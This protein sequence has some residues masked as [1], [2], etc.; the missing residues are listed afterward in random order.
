MKIIFSQNSIMDLERIHSFIYERNQDAAHKVIRK[1]YEAIQS[2]PAQ[3]E[4]G[5]P[6]EKLGGFRELIVSRHVVRYRIKAEAI[7][8]IRI[9]HQRQKPL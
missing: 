4:K 6:V 5:R 9:R 1:L 8:I 7:E 2:L 3:P